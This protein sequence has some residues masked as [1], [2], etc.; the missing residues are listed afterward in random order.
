M[1]ESNKFDNMYSKIW[2]IFAW[3][4]F[5]KIRRVLIHQISLVENIQSK[6]QMAK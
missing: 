6:F 1:A 4:N 3:S 2:N 5:L